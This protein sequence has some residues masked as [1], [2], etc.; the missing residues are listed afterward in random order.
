[1]IGEHSLA[2]LAA[3]YGGVVTLPDCALQGLSIDSRALAQGDIFLA[4]RGQR[5]DGHDFI[6][7]VVS[8]GARGLIVER[9]FRQYPLPQW[10]VDD[11]RLALGQV[12]RGVRMASSA[13]VVGITGSTGKTTVKTLVA[14]ICAQ[15]GEV[16]ATRGNLNN[17]I[18][19]PLSLLALQP[20]HR[21]AVIEMGAAQL[22][23]I[24]YLGQIVMPDV[25]LITNI[26]VAHMERFGSQRNIVQAKGEIY[27]SLGEDGTAVINLDTTGADY[28]AQISPVRQVTFSMRTGC[29]ADIWADRVITDVSGSSFDLH[30]GDQLAPVRLALLG[31]ANVDNAL[32]AA[33]VGRALDL[34]VRQVV[35]GLERVRPV[36]GRLNP[37]QVGGA[38]L[39][40]DAYNANPASVRAAIAV[41]AEFSGRRVLV[42]GDM[43][44]LGPQAETMHKEVGETARQAGI[45][46]LLAT[47]P[48]SAAAVKSFG[49][50]GR[51]FASYADLAAF[52]E[53]ELKSGDTWLI[54]GSRSAGLDRLVTHLSKG[55][56]ACCSG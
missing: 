15:A 23:D 50:A 12:A 24:A 2:G 43:G 8:Q 55:E 7:Q 5:F 40:D 1:M 13:A 44:E 11:S 4:L 31:R 42:L 51:W 18:G 27:E 9:P 53:A 39:L 30:Y 21:Y 33:A 26:G 46:M 38:T 3:R 56:G 52:A 48:L 19:V 41:L 49:E 25:A 47:G 37:V 6:P 17:E 20:Q 22:G 29:G 28:F 10:V 36:A 14:A 34:D 54:K 35:A 32:A 45:D 16:L